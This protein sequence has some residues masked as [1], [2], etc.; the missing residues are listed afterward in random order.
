MKGRPAIIRRLDA[1]LAKMRAKDMEVRAIYLTEA[2]WNEYNKVQSKAYGSKM[3]CFLYGGY[4]IRGGKS[5]I[6]YS[7][8]GVGVTIPIK[9][10]PNE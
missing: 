7:K 6:I 10:V 3:I 2:D 1:A 8:Q 9:G 5:S 4:E